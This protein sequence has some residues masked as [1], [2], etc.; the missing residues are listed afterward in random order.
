MRRVDGYSLWL[1]HVGDLRKPADLHAAGVE[2]IVELA[3]NEKPA[4]LPREFVHC[5]FPLVDGAGNPA[6]LLRAAIG[7]VASLIE[8]HVPTLVCCGVGMSRTPAVAAAALAMTMRIPP[9]DALA[10]V[11]RNGPADVSTSLWAEIQ[12]VVS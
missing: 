7:T 5:R 11:T 12:T 10:I 2:A 6:W 3:V 9:S 1:G 4:D 8:L